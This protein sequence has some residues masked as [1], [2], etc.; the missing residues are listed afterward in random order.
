M[1]F[2]IET[3]LWECP[4][5]ECS[6]ISMPRRDAPKGQ[7]VVGKGN[8]RL[9]LAKDNL[10][11]THYYVQTDDNVMIDITDAITDRETKR[12]GDGMWDIDLMLRFSAVSE[13]PE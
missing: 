10:N 11:T 5:T 1:P 2:S 6:L 9:F 13:P 12:R 7:P 3:N 8:V 4:V